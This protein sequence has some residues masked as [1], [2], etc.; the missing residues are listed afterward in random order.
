MCGLCHFS[1]TVRLKSS[2]LVRIAP[3]E[4]SVIVHLLKD[5]SVLIVCFLLQIGMM[6]RHVKLTR[7]S[8]QADVRGYSYFIELTKLERK[9]VLK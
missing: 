2:L 9:I 7:T 1:H 6:A 5:F 3:I 4:N 8:T